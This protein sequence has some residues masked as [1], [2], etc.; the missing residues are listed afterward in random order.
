MTLRPRC[1]SHTEPQQ[2][3]TFLHES[4][5]AIDMMLHIGL[6]EDQTHLLS[7]GF[8]AFIRDNKLDFLNLD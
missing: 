5:H 8:L 6:D 1:E 7:V 4:I 3:T 2:S